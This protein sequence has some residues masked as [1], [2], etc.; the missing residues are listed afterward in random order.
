MV[1]GIIFCLLTASTAQVDP[2]STR[3][4]I[5]QP[6]SLREAVEIA[7]RESPILR[8]AVAELKASGSAAANGKVGKTMATFPQR[9][10]Q[11]GHGKRH[12]CLAT[13]CHA[14]C[15]D[16]VAAPNFL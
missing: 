13:N 2:F 4:K 10:R 15:H 3:P 14:V 1:L 11:H 12:P 16:A 5:R 9:L 8:G 7:L 6:L